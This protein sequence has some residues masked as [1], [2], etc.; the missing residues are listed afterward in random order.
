MSNCFGN[1]RPV[2][3]KVSNF[4][5]GLRPHAGLS[6]ADLVF[7]YY[8]GFGGTRF[9]AIF[10]GQDTEQAGPVRSARLIDG[11]LGLVY[12]PIFAFVSADPFVLARIRNM[13]RER[14]I[15]EVA[16][17]CPALCRTGSG[18]VNSVFVDT[19]LLTQYAEEDR[20]IENIRQDLDGTYFDPITPDG[21]TSGTWLRVQYAPKTLSEWRYDPASERYLRWIEQIDSAN[22]VTVVELTDRLTG[23]QLSFANVVVLFVFHDEIKPTLHDIEILGNVEGKQALLFRNGKMFEIVWKSVDGNK[24]L[25]FFTPD[26]D[27]IA[28]KPG[29]TWFE[30]VGVSSDEFEVNPGEWEVVFT[31]P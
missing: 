10:Y 8:I 17:S 23:E 14:A 30:V 15:T 24:P 11:E 20:G 6:F 16:G 13:L 19:A 29:N 2:V 27:L 25:Q 31:I 18:D 12:Q 9:S 22:N 5:R 4:P 26:G 3:V 1:I 28:F 21:G 7:E